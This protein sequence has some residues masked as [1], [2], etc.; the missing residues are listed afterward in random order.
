MT[1]V[2]IFCISCLTCILSSRFIKNHNTK[3]VDIIHNNFRIFKYHHSSDFLIFLQ[4]L[5][6]IIKLEIYT[7]KEILLLMS[8][9]QFLRSICSITTVLPPLKN[10]KD[11]IRFGGLNGYGTEYIFSGHASYSAVT[12]LFLYSENILG[13]YTLFLYNCISQLLIVVSR[14][15]YTIDV[16]LAWIISSLLYSNL[17][18]CK[19]NEDCFE[20]VNQFI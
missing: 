10:Y 17:Q 11:K 19:R 4:I 7:I 8:I 18:L 9:I 12:T 6:G 20:M 1:S 15:H 14:N 3:I 13:F 16:L 2:Y 5:F